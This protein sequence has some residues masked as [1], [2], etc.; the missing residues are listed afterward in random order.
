VMV[1]TTP[2][3][4]ELQVRAQEQRSEVL[5]QR[6]EQLTPAETAE[7]LAA[8]PALETLATR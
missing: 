8:L 3:G 1:E 4:H 7:L 6:L 5:S 2:L